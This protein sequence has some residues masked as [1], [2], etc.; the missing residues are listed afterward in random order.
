MST[1]ACFAE[2]DRASYRQAGAMLAQIDNQVM[3]L[4][5]TFADGLL[6]VLHQP[7][8]QAGVKILICRADAIGFCWI[9]LVIWR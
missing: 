2:T 5:P 8:Q 6:V 4:S 3:P 1:S 7:R 9:E